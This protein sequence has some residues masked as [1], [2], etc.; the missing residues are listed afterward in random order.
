MHK[1]MEQDLGWTTKSAGLSG[2]SIHYT[3][4]HPSQ[5]TTVNLEIKADDSCE[6]TLEG[7]T[8]L[9]PS[10]EALTAAL[11]LPRAATKLDQGR[12]LSQVL[13]ELLRRHRTVTHAAVEDMMGR[14]SRGHL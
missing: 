11:K 3:M 4:Q 2:N 14:Y 5:P 12:I 6:I 1:F 8:K 9:I 7:E 13:D 10:R